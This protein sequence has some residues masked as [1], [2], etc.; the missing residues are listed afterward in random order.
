MK[1]VDKKAEEKR[2]KDKNTEIEKNDGE[3]EYVQSKMR[4]EEGE[5]ETRKRTDRS[6]GMKNK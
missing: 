5:F 4:R 1:N 6:K 3:A 2:R